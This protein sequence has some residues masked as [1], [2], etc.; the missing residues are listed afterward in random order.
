MSRPAFLITID[1]EGDNLWSRPKE[2]TTRNASFLPRFQALC[3][4]HRFKP[5][6][7]T[8]WEMA[9]SDAFREFGQE[10]LRTGAGEIGMHL[11]AWNSPPLV[12]LTDD[13]FKHVPFVNEYP[14][15]QIRDKVNMLT[16]KLENAFAV[17]MESHRAGRWGISGTYMQIIAERGYIVDCSVTPHL[18]WRSAKGDPAGTGGPDFTH[19]PEDAYFMDLENVGT[20]GDSTLLELPV[21][22]IK[23]RWPAPVELMRQLVQRHRKAG[24]A[25]ARLFPVLHWF[26]PDGRNRTELLAVLDAALRQK[27][28]YVEFMLHSSEFMPG[29]SPTFPSPESIETLYD[30]LE[31]VFGA[32]A[33]HFDGMTLTDYYH[34]FRGRSGHPPGLTGSNHTK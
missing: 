34:R 31:V 23:R 22:I 2:I 12:P 1:T 5:T 4:R 26:R 24:R 28:D 27:R 29:G 11:H 19:F 18:S 21:T 20:A 13:D 10:V 14:A 30:D 33:R 32:A 16:D 25:M 3:E 7:L 8:N 6:Y 15:S 17:K 9:G